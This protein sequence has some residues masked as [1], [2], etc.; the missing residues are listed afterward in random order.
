MTFPSWR[1]LR[2]RGGPA[3]LPFQVIGVDALG[4]VG[5][6]LAI[7]GIAKRDDEFGVFFDALEQGAEFAAL[8]CWKGEGGYVSLACCE[9]I[10][11]DLL[12]GELTILCVYGNAAA[13]SGVEIRIR[14][15][16]ER[17]F[18]AGI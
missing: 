5:A 17:V 9:V 10:G 1:F 14:C 16:L 6:I 7:A 4:G 8:D 3:V 12:T 2:S 18:V 15:L 11:T 13:H